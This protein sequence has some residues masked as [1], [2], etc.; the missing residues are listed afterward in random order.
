MTAQK[1][2]GSDFERRATEIL[3]RLIN[4]SNWKRIPGSGAMGT[5]LDESL[6]MGDIKGEV[7]KF[8]YKFRGECKTGYS[9]RTGGEAKSFTL[10]KE[11]L[12]K[13]KE[14]A[15]KSFS[16]PFLIGHFDGVRVGVK[17]FIVM[18]VDD[19]SDIINKYTD[20]KKEL[21][22]LYERRE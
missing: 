8:P 13:I 9:N 12:D 10:K 11:W 7:E 15:K 17:N 14:E 22:L 1:R 2:K 18:D 19:F 20:L 3:N 16:F 5:S 4:N 6:L 21:D